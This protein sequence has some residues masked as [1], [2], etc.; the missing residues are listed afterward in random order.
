MLAKPLKGK[1]WVQMSP[2]LS[3]FMKKHSLDIM[4]SEPAPID[5]QMSHDMFPKAEKDIRMLKS[6]KG[7]KIEAMTLYT[8]IT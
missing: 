6:I 5:A 8:D 3:E 2:E 7:F 4:R 1:E